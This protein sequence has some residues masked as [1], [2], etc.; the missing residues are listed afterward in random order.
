MRSFA[1]IL[2][3]AFLSTG[4]HEVNKLFYFRERTGGNRSNSTKTPDRESKDLVKAEGV[5]ENK[6]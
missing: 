3:N 1:L 6:R 2:L 5:Y 4:L